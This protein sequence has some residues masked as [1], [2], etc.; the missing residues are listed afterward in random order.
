MLIGFISFLRQV[1]I[2]KQRTLEFRAKVFTALML[3]KKNFSE[4]D[5]KII[6]NI[7]WKIYE[8][9]FIN[10]FFLK[11]TIKEFTMRYR[12]MNYGLDKILKEISRELKF[13][14][15]YANKIDFS[16]LRELISKKNEEEAFLQERVYEFLLSEVESHKT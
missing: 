5:F 14:K 16:Y 2:T 15:K 12:E 10:A 4:N 6:E 9:D 7:S 11:Y 1:F 8:N 13:N 3:C